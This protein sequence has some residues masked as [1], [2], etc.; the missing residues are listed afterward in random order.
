MLRN[1]AGCETP[2]W[3][4]RTGRVDVSARA[5][6]ARPFPEATRDRRTPLLGQIVS[7]NPACTGHVR[8]R[9]VR[10]TPEVGSVRP[11]SCDPLGTELLD[12]RGAPAWQRDG[13]IEPRLGRRVVD[14]AQ[15]PELRLRQLGFGADQRVRQLLTGAGPERAQR[16][17]DESAQPLGPSARPQPTQ[18]LACTVDLGHHRLLVS[19]E[20]QRLVHD[21]VTHAP[22][23]SGTMRCGSGPGLSHKGGS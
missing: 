23:S 9:A 22:A 5:V 8:G 2:A 19:Q 12:A 15:A 16:Q 6:A 18:G 13:G 21:R 14:S 1:T 10:N 3:S 4:R 20:S 17:P 11:Q 7:S